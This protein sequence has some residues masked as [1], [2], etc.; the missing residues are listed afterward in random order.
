VC[1]YG[2]AGPACAC[3]EGFTPTDPGDWSKG[4]RRLFDLRCGEEVY[5]AELP[6]VDYWGF[7][8]NFKANISFEACRKICLDDCNCEAF[9]YKKGGE[10]MCYAKNSLWNGRGS[11]LK[12]FI[13]FKVPTRVGKKLNLSSVLSL[14]FDGHACPKQEQKASVSVYTSRYLKDTG[15]DKI[16]FVYFY[17]FLAGLFVVEAIVIVAGYLLMFRADRA[18]TRRVHDEGYTLVFSQFRRFTYEELSNATCDFGDELWR[19]A[20]GA[21]YKGVLDDGRDVAVMRLAE[22]MPQA[23]DVF[24]SEL[25]VIGRIN[26]M[27]LVRVWGFCSEHSGRLLVSEHVENGSLAK[28]LFG[29]A[30]ELTLGWRSRYKIAVGVAKGLAYLHHECLEWI[31]HCDVKPENILL[32]AALEPKITGFGLVKLLSRDDEAGRAPSRVQVT[33]GYAAPEWA[34]SLPITGKADVYSFG[35]VLLELLR[36]KRLSESAAADS[37]QGE[38][39]RVD[40]QGIV[41]WIENQMMECQGERSEQAQ[42]LEEFVDV[43][44]LGDFNRLQAAAML[45]VAVSCIEDDPSRRPSMNIVVEKL[46]SCEN[47]G[48]ASLRQVCPATGF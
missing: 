45:E 1:T 20:S 11:E 41:A 46:L 42:W 21:V 27:N 18:A 16:N 13:Y 22:V 4:C 14:R 8:R 37:P 25:S 32:D 6:N 28:A 26:H 15:G 29:G 3:P 43:Q 47:V 31:L 23:D 39:G 40:L 33:R 48:S 19:G 24:R 35:V 30:E 12:Q 44:V 9:G 34:L 17:S 36:G 10:G 5:F 2:L 38:G 7:D